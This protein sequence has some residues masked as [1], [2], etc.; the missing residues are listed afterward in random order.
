MEQQRCTLPDEVLRG[1]RQTIGL[2]SGGA[3][4]IVG[5]GAG[6][7]KRE[8]GGTKGLRKL[9]GW[10]TSPSM[11]ERLAKKRTGKSKA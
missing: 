2:G 11:N 7:N 1:C 9:V 10:S 3:T 4:R 5:V 6:V 8:T